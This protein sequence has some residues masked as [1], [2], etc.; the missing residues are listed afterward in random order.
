MFFYENTAAYYLTMG[1]KKHRRVRKI[2]PTDSV[3]EFEL[4]D[5]VSDIQWRREEREARQRDEA[6]QKQQ[7]KEKTRRKEARVE[8]SHSQEG[9]V[10]EKPRRERIDT[11]TEAA[12][13]EVEASQ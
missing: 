8:E 12:G 4:G 1:R 3:L 11:E 7:R 10:A 9:V 13:E 2:V 5:T 6:Q